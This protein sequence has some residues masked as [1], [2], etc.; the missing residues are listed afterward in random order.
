MMPKGTLSLQPR[1][2]RPAGP[3]RAPRT[4]TIRPRRG[5]ERLRPAAGA[6]TKTLKSLLQDAHVPLNDRAN[7]PLIF[8]DERLIAVS[9][10][11]LDASVG[12]PPA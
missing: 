5:G 3:R 8:A 12:P 2:S 9:D 4:L 11:W 7:L 10:R 1:P 6:R